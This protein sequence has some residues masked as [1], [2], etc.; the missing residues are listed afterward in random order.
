MGAEESSIKK[1]ISIVGREYSV[2]RGDTKL[3]EC[4]WS[5]RA[6]ANST[7]RSASSPARAGVR[8]VARWFSVMHSLSS[9]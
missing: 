5:E 9:T 2:L 7:C 1:R 3:D 6:T 8:S 4:G